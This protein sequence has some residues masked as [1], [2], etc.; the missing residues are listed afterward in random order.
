MGARARLRS[1]W[2]HALRRSALEQEMAEELA[3]HI[4]QRAEALVASR[5]LDAGEAMRLARLEFGAID[6][7]KEEA[8]QSLGLRLLDEWRGDLRYAWRTLWRARGFAA[9]AIATLAVGIGATTAIF[10]VLNAVVLRPL[11]VVRP[12]ELVEVR[13]QRPG[14]EP[15]SGFS[16]ALWEAVRDEQDV[17]TRTFAWMG[18]RPLQLTEGPAAGPVQVLMVSGDFFETLGVTPAAGRLIADGDD[19]RGCPPV[20]VLSDAFWA[21][22]SSRSPAAVGGSVHLSRL[23]F[24]VIGVA[25]PVFTGVTLG[26]RF[27]VAIPLC[28]AAL[29]DKRNIESRGRQWLAIAGRLPAGRSVEHVTARLALQ[30][31]AILRAS[32][33]GPYTEGGDY[34]ER[35]IVAVPG[36]I[37]AASFRRA[38]L[39]P[40]QSLMAIVVVVLV[41]AAANIAGLMAARAATRDREVAIRAALGASRGRLVRQMLTESAAICLL[42]ALCGLLVARWLSALIVRG[43]STAGNPVH[44]DHSIDLRVLAVTAVVTLVTTLVIGLAPA[45]RSARA[46]LMD[47]MKTRLGASE[48]RAG[49]RAGT[50]IVAGQVA[51]SL[52]L[53]VAGGLLLRTFVNL[54]RLD[55]GFDRRDVLVVSARQP[56]YASDLTTLAVE[57]KPVVYEEIARRLAAVPGVASVAQAYTTPI[58]ETNW[59]TRVQADRPGAAPGEAAPAHLNFVS[60]GYFATLRQPLLRGRDFNLSDSSSSPRVAIVNETLARRFFPDGQA[61]GGRFR[62]GNGTD[63]T[64]VI[65]IVRDTNYESVRQ[66]VPATAFIPVTQMPEDEAAEEFVLRTDVPAATVVPA[67]RQVAAEVRRDLS[68]KATT[69]EARIA[70]NLARERLIATL[71]GLFGLTGLGLAMIGLYGAL[72]YLVTARQAEL[73][74]RMA[75]GAPRGSVLRLVMKEVARVLTVGLVAGAAGVW[76]ATRLL[77]QLLYGLDA[78]D[79]TT[80]VVAA[81][82]LAVVVLLAS[83]LPA[84][85]ATR[86][87]PVVAL[88]AE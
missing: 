70:D 8:R 69:I 49:A 85:R 32:L 4:Q 3:F 29:L 23:A 84:R 88:R 66:P 31:P 25:S 37:G 17:L 48:A 58:G 44:L 50:W 60:P 53:L 75:I 55:L 5:G 42:G 81:G 26:T 59:V 77:D 18:P 14:R 28:A 40:L 27:D 19:Q 52:M 87:D 12:H 47:A 62:R 38:F 39:T 71:A 56:W 15:E 86:I 73:G 20:A 46:A 9:A 57:E 79:A 16:F 10:S 80:I 74:I 54:S 51:L 76:P 45:L 24:S 82:L 63:T 36:P 67:I 41:I 68:L 13:Y 72:S 78:Q 83:Y 34:L 22:Q 61:L 65:G 21:R 33:D 11:P 64:E 30:S 43:L 2:R 1:F 7:F 35:R 6:K